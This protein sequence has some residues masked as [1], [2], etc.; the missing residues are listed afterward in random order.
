M[1]TDRCKKLM[2]FASIAGILTAVLSGCGTVDEDGTGPAAYSFS[3]PAEYRAMVQLTGGTIIGNDVYAYDS[4]NKG[5]FPTGRTVTLSPFKIAKYETT[6]ELWYEVYQWA[7]GHGYT[8][9]N[10]G[11][12]GDNGTDG[13]APTAAKNESATTINWRDAIVWCNAYSEMSGKEPVYYT[14]NSHTTVLRVSMNDSGT[15]TP[16][17]SAVMKPGANGYRLPTAAEWEYAARGGNQADTVNWSYNYA[18]SDTLGDVAWY[19]VNAYDVGAG[20]ADY[21]VH[22]VGTK[23]EN[24]AGLYDM[25]GNVTEWGWDWCGAISNTET[26]TDPAGPA[27]NWCRVL[28]GGS[29]GDDICAVASGGADVA[30]HSRWG[31]IGF[32]L[33]CR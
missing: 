4:T 25:S 18:G 21:G 28:L 15:G 30:P 23:T 26:V 22:P 27:S 14:D 2:A 31:T 3:T 11:R 9:A 33:A 6:Y 5:M 13:A 12:E 29:W 1:K 7:A 19:K 32:R 20:S 8:F 16:V 17:D 10:P 24:G